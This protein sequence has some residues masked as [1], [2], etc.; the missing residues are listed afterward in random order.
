MSGEGPLAR[1]RR[2]LRPRSPRYARPFR[3]RLLVRTRRGLDSQVQGPDGWASWAGPWVQFCPRFAAAGADSGRVLDQE[4]SPRR[5]GV[6]SLDSASSLGWDA[7]A[8][9]VAAAAR[10][11]V[12]GAS[13]SGLGGAATP[14]AGLEHG[15]R[16][17]LSARGRVHT[18]SGLEE[19]ASAGATELVLR[20]GD[21]AAGEPRRMPTTPRLVRKASGSG[22]RWFREIG[23]TRTAPPGGNVAGTG[24][25]GLWPPGGTAE[26]GGGRRDGPLGAVAAGRC[27]R[28]RAERGPGAVRDGR[29]RA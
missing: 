9:G 10:R 16:G 23:T 18:R 19:L 22:R 6:E 15:P 27:G 20:P 3:A 2:S 24:R 28:A 17:E 12:P 26:R 4:S 13:P 14:S 11:A 7:R 29:Q 1:A 21:A 5:G 25:S 8:P